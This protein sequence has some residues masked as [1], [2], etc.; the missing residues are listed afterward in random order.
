MAFLRT[1][2][3]YLLLSLW[4]LVLAAGAAARRLEAEG[5]RARWARALLLAAVLGELLAWDG[6]FVSLER[7]RALAPN[8]EVAAAVGGR[9]FRVLTDPELA[10]PDKA[11][12]YRARNANGYE[13]FFLAG[14]P[15]YAAKSEGRAAVD[16]SRSYLSRHDTPEMSRLGVATKLLAGGG[17][18]PNPRALPLAHF[19]DGEGRVLPAAVSVDLPRAEAWSV[20]AAVP[21]GARRLVAAES[22]FPGWRAWLGGRPAR[23]ERWDGLVQSVE[24]PPD[25]EPGQ[26]L[27]LVLRYAPRLWGLW[28]GLS[29]LA[30]LALAWR[31]A[32]SPA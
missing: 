22:D 2:S 21:A 12:L 17:F 15:E 25:A 28:A 10:N 9:A 23:L 18:E 24:L 1:P 16:S 6:R 29:A 14:F 19:E 20:R 8:P 26:A 3:R 32:R 4:G 5:R 7:P 11:M 31:A 13:A 30:W 27:E